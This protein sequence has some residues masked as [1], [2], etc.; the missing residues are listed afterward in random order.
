MGR[1]TSGVIGMRFRGDDELLAMDVVREGA[2]L[3]T[4]T[5]G[6]FWKRT[7]LS[8]WTAKGRGGLG[9]IAMK[10][11]EHRGSLVGA[12]VV[13]EGDEVLAITESGGVIRT[14]V[15]EEALQRRARDTMGVRLMAV[16][17]GDAVVGVARN[18]DGGIDG[19][20][21][22]TVEDG[23]GAVSDAPEAVSDAET[24]PAED[25]GDQAAQA[26]TDGVGEE[27]A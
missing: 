9:M 3:V 6:G 24:R 1:A 2:D 25:A 4:F 18:A 20:D 19:D 17:E 7:A 27:G 8:E 16:A 11:P 10:L 5:D 12:L 14:K 13:D 21:D 26:P 23:V 22:D 15:S